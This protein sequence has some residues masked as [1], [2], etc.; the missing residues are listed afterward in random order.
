LRKSV[1]PTPPPEAT[2]PAGPPGG[3]PTQGKLNSQEAQNFILKIIS[4]ST[5]FRKYFLF[6]FFGDKK[7]L[8]MSRENFLQFLEPFWYFIWRH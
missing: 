6:L 4:L 3:Q 7:G 5:F 1:F 8:E 2:H